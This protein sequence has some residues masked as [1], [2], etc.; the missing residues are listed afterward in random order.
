MRGSSTVESK[1]LY[2][3]DQDTPNVSQEYLKLKD[4]YPN[5]LAIIM[6]PQNLTIKKDRYM[7]PG[8]ITFKEF[9]KIIRSYID[10][11]QPLFFTANDVLL[12]PKMVIGDIYNNHKKTDG[13]LHISIFGE[14]GGTNATL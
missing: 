8:H 5:S 9:V 13:F 14:S 7:A 11:D 2:D 1:N 6:H 10:S 12:D 3:P 4:K